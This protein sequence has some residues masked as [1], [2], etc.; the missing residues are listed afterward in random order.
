MKKIFGYI[1]A[2][3]LACTLASCEKDGILPEPEPPVVNPGGNQE[4]E[5]PGEE[6]EKTRLGV[7]ATLQ[8]M[9]Q[10]RGIIEAFV[11]GHAMGVFVNTD[12][13]EAAG[14]KNASYVFDGK[15]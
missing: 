2:A 9:Q 7:T 13:T 15:E 8:G 12:G 6:P 14:T 1:L 4:E 10:T 5:E 11:P 3:S